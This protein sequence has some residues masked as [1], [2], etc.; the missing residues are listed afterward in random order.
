TAC[1]S[2]ERITELVFDATPPP[3]GFSFEK[4]GKRIHLDVAGVNSAMA[5]SLSGRL[6]TDVHIAAGG[7][8]PTPLYLTATCDYLREKPLKAET[9]LAAA[10]IAQTEIAPIDDLRGSAVYKRLLF[11][12]LFFAHFLKLF[13]DRISWEALHALG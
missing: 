7:V 10:A 11:R 3:S 13:P 5:I 9:V 4:V 1:R 12:Q 6:V 2:G 8:A